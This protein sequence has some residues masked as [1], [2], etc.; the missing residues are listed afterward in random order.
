M[1]RDRERLNEAPT[2]ILPQNEAWVLFLIQ[3]TLISREVETS[4]RSS[5]GRDSWCAAGTNDF[6]DRSIVRPHG[7]PRMFG[8]VPWPTSGPGGRS[9][10]GSTGVQAIAVPPQP[11]WPRN[12]TDIAESPNRSSDRYHGRRRNSS[13]SRMW[14]IDH[15]PSRM[16]WRSFWPSYRLET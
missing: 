5:F 12:R 16:R 14:N 8:F 7:G 1:D 3:N 6:S 9:Y 2:S 11:R 4:L 13:R 10:Q 15:F